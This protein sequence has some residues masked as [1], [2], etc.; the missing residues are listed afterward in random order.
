MKAILLQEPELEFGT[1][2]HVDI[3]FGLMAHGP[4]DF[5][6][7]PASRIRAGIV[8]S[9]E[10][11]GFGHASTTPDAPIRGRTAHRQSVRPTWGQ[12]CR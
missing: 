3:R 10:S 8:G 11:P 4:V 2:R 12:N 1:G 6:D 9:P 5:E 7:S